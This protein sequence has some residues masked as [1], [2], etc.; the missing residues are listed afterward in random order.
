[1]FV[2]HTVPIK[3]LD[4]PSQLLTGTVHFEV[5]GKYDFILL[6]TGLRR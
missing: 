3:R 2:L 6:A 1:M 5:R 4:T